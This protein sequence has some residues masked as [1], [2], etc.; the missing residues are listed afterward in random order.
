M[1]LARTILLSLLGFLLLIFIVALFFPKTYTV[2]R[3]L[4]IKQ[5]A[6]KLYKE[7]SDYNDFKEWNPWSETDSTTKKIVEGQPSHSG[8]KYSWEGQ[9]TGK[10][11]IIITETKSPTMVHSRLITT[12]PMESESE[13]D[14]TIEP[15][16]GGTKVTWKNQGNLD[17]PFGRYFGFMVKDMLEKDFDKGLQNLK[18]YAEKH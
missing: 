12:T 11:Y 15:V 7:I 8:H 16:E 6:E 9:K 4:V 13:V 18:N 1:K 3:S 17:Y 10:G 2:Q 14:F 5:P